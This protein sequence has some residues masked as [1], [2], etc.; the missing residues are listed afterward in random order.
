VNRD[1]T[2][3]LSAWLAQG[4][5]RIGQIALRSTAA[6]FELRHVE[7]EARTDLA[8][9]TR[10]EDARPLANADDAG[11]F[12]PLKTV[13]TLRHAWRLV[14][15]DAAEVRKALDYFCAQRSAVRPVCMRSPRR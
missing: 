12:R 5:A 11:N 15:R 13:P 1:L 7:D 10:W 14:L 8:L 6:G 4:G 3:T 9:F 2:A